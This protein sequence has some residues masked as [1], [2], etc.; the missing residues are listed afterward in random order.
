MS[1]PINTIMR[2]NG[3]CGHVANIV[4]LWPFRGP[5]VYH[6]VSSTDNDGITKVAWMSTTSYM[7]G[8]LSPL[9]Y[10]SLVRQGCLL[11]V[12]GA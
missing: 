4:T 11:G 10:F 9:Q 6:A 5:Y 12:V 8:L 3:H 1:L 2:H 7:L